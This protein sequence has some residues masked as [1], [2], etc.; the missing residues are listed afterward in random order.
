MVNYILTNYLNNNNN[1]NN[2]LIFVYRLLK[3]IS[4]LLQLIAL[5]QTLLYCH[6][7]DFALQPCYTY[8]F[9][10][11]YLT[12]CCEIMNICMRFIL[13]IIF[14]IKSQT[15]FAQTLLSRVNITFT[16]TI[17]AKFCGAEIFIIGNTQ[18]LIAAKINSFIV[19]FVILSEFHCISLI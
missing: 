14:G 16:F 6:T 5:Q 13:R 1:S 8:H 12:N 3:L 19:V 11:M 17:I 15:L 7:K 2:N 18:T 10:A 9:T 4:R